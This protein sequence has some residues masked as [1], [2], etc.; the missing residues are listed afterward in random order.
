MAR[1]IAGA[2]AS[3]GSVHSTME[4]YSGLRGVRFLLIGLFVLALIMA[5]YHGYQNMGPYIADFFRTGQLPSF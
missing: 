2:N 4:D 5:I 1:R 3:D